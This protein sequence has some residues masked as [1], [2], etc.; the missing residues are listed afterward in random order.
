MTSL[1]EFLNDLNEDN[2]SPVT[3]VFSQ[4]WLTPELALRRQFQPLDTLEFT[5]ASLWLKVSYVQGNAEQE[6]LAKELLQIAFTPRLTA[7]AQARAREL[8]A[9]GQRY[10][11]DQ[12]TGLPNANAPLF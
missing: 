6:A 12:V 10:L 4:W 8:L 5:C 3:P 2:P 11:A 9:S 7:A 1:S